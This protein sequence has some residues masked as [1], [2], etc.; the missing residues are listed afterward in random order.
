M[1]DVLSDVAGVPRDRLDKRHHP[2]PFCHQGTDCF[3][4]VDEDAGSV[5]CNKCFASKNGDFLAAIR[6]AKNYSFPQAL[7]AAAEYLGVRPVNGEASGAG[8]QEDAM[9]LVCR[10]KNI[11][12]ASVIAYGAR[13]GDGAVAFPSWGPD[14]EA[15]AKFT[16]KPRGSDIDRKG[17]WPKGSKGKCGVF[18]PVVDDKPRLPAEGET[19]LIFEGPKD[20]CAAHAL[21]FLAV[22]MNT[23]KLNQRFVKL[24]RGVHVVLV[25]DR[26]TAGVGGADDAARKLRGVAATIKIAA[27]PA[28]VKE[29]NGADL[30][31]ILAKEGGEVLARE[32]IDQATECK[33]PK[34][35]GVDTRPRIYNS[36]RE[37]EVADEA[38]AALA[39]LPGLYQRGGNLVSVVRDP[40]PPA[41]IIRPPGSL[42]LTP[43][44]EPG[45]LDRLSQAAQFYVVKDTDEGPV[46]V[47]VLPPLRVAKIVRSRQHWPGVP[48]I[49]AI[50]HA[51]TFLADG[52]VLTK[53]G[54]DRATGLYLAGN[55][56]FPAVPESPTKA[57][58]ERARD[59]LREVV[60][61]FPFATPAHEAA[62]LALA[63]T[64]AARF[65]FDGPTPLGAF[66]ANVRG[67]GK[68]KLADSIGMI[69]L[70]T[71]LSRTAA[72]SSDE[73]FR[74]RIT[75]TLLG[76]ERIVLIDNVAGMLGCP[77]LDALL[78]QVTLLA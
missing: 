3:R 25:P 61:D 47:D 68:S 50:I 40:E 70:G 8:Q 73:E 37:H 10:E 45:T 60:C 30:R 13:M 42:Y 4:L 39:D 53:C 1:L 64:P 55:T 9:E 21:G 77:S 46:E 34:S 17:R 43:I 51:P 11:K 52:S 76:G 22:G 67:S 29:S 41:G 5:L 2:C 38:V 66:D 32:A 24:F 57:D 26:D 19:W 31:D 20:P 23:C 7:G 69:H 44:D 49:E 28:E 12:P 58:A 62:W 63:I 14:G 15:F 59:E 27:L 72:P 35:E 48:A 6:H 18:L 33:L 78:T 16:I 54:Y 56:E 71:E 36:T 75:A 74:K 65:A